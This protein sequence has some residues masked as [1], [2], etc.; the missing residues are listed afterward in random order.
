MTDANGNITR[1]T[2]DELGQMLTQTDAQN[3]MVANQYDA[4][5]N[6]TQ[7]V[8]ARGHTTYNYYDNLGRLTASR[9]SENY[10][11][12]TQYSNFGEVA[13]IIRRYN[14][15][16]GAGPS[17]VAHA[18][19]AI[20]G[21]Q[22]DRRGLVTR[23][24]DAEGF[25]EIYEYDGFGNRT[26]VTNKLAGVTTNGYD[27]R[28]LFIAET[29]FQS[30]YNSAGTLTASSVTDTHS[31]DARGN[32]TQTIAAAGLTEARKTQ[33]AYDKANRLVE[34]IGQTFLGQTPHEYIRYDAR[35]NV[36]ATTDPSGARNVFFYDDLNRKI[37]EI[38]ALGTYSSFVYDRND[39]VTETRIYE[40]VVG[41]PADGGSAA[42][43]PAAPGGASRLTT[44][45][46]DSLNRLLT[47]NVA[48]AVYG[49]WNGVG[50]ASGTSTLTTTYQYDANGNVIKTT[51]PR[52]YSTY[53]YY[54]R[55]G[56][57]TYQ[58]DAEQYR[59]DWSYDA[60]GNVTGEYRFGTQ[61]APAT[62]AGVPGA[63]GSADDRVT[64]FSYDRNGNRLGETRANV[65]INNGSGAQIMTH[66]TITFAY[67]GL[68]QV[69]QKIEATGERLDYVYDTSGRLTQEL[70]AAMT[71]YN[72]SQIRPTTDY[73]YNGMGNLALTRQQ[74]A[75]GTAERI[76]RYGYD[77]DKLRVVTDP[78][79]FNRYYWYDISGRV[80]HDYYT[81]A[82]SDGTAAAPLEGNL[83]GYDLLGRATI[84][85]QATYAD[86]VGWTTQG[87]A[88]TTAYNA[89]GDIASV[90]VGGI[91]QQQNK[92]DNAGRLWASTAGDGIWKYFGYDKNGNQ[93]LVITS[94]GYDLS[95]L[96]LD[97]A[98]ALIDRD[99]VNATYTVFDR[100][101]QAAITYEEGRQIDTAPSRRLAHSV[102]YNAFGEIS[103]EVDARD[104]GTTYTYNT[105]G[106]LIKKESP[107]VQVTAENG[108]VSTIRPTENYYYDISGRLTAS[109]DANGNLT[110]RD[111]LAGT[112]YGGS[113]ALV[114]AEFHADGGVKTMQYDIHGDLRR[115]TDEVGR[116]T[117]QSFDG[118]GRV[119]QITRPGG[120]TL[121][122]GY[123][124]LGQRLWEYNSV[125]GSGNRQTTDY[126]MQGRVISTRAYGGDVTTTSYSWDGAIATAGLGTFGG[127]RQTT[128]TQA[129]RVSASDAI[130]A[131]VQVSDLFGRTIT[132]SD[133]G[134]RSYSYGYDLAGRLTTETST[135]YGAAL[136]N[137]GYSYYNTGQLV[138]LV[139]GPANPAADTNWKR[140]TSSYSYDEL[141]RLL[142]EKLVSEEGHYTPEYYEYPTGNP[143]SGP[144]REIQ[145]DDEP[146]YHP[147]TYYVSTATLQD[148]R[149]NYDAL[150]RMESYR[151][152]A[153]SGAD[154]ASMNWRYD[155]A[156]NVRNMRSVY[157]AMQANGALA[158]GTSV[159]DY[160]YR[161]DTMNRMVV[162]KGTLSGGVI[163][164]GGEGTDLSY[165]A[166]GERKTAITGYGAQ[167]SYAYNADGLITSVTVGG[168]TRATTSF[169][170]LGRTLGHAEYD[171]YGTVVHERSAIVYDARGQVLSEKGRT[172]QGADWLY[173]HTVNHYSADGAGG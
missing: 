76:T 120:L 166:A 41:V 104:F 16:T 23:S 132:R 64:Y 68:G 71:D 113:E 99:D 84:Q 60:E 53:S 36:T 39:N 48:G 144:P 159:Q 46:Y 117:T 94:A 158:A 129:D 168:A 150:G 127:W 47:S 145:P 155:S 100:R 92:Y 119:T 149:A 34:T 38:N 40:N 154:N 110:R 137:I 89:Y 15:A 17:V 77:G 141:G 85:Y 143:R 134:G 90:A 37:A 45:T 33:Y 75:A 3:G 121:Y 1:Y 126:D 167:E 26:R 96:S 146:I 8:D 95:N 9:D 74:G 91:T 148:G 86:S 111:L 58:V 35:G 61:V 44:F 133:M 32:L 83:T 160:W 139:S 103:S 97:Q 7:N 51:D 122:Y 80:T 106:R 135:L 172:R 93:N 28:G 169:D 164:R 108:A 50:Y 21:F 25:A 62:V 56:R 98:K 82:K 115:L 73:Y 12:E 105:L 67:N 63:V 22:Y 72:G 173:T 20:T 49:E 18:K 69:V 152:V 5:G 109:R 31:Y 142:T 118:A 114:T 65:L 87:P 107:Y 124:G 112:G 52:G 11:T 81:R 163:A 54:D 19:D 59:T 153:V 79:G 14:S 161:Y 78:R 136:R 2:Y 6:V 138:R 24:T 147:A 27:R 29:R 125:L 157:L 162:T 102:R 131:A 42:E 70:S 66:A 57:K 88:A 156:G 10:I 43:A 170:A 151:D 123:D 101:G 13:Q 165:N 130:Y 55:L 128:S 171:A 4:F 116:V 140:D 30:V